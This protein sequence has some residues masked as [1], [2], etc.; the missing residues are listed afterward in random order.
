MTLTTVRC[1]AVS[2]ARFDRVGQRTVRALGEVHRTENPAELH[3]RIGV[4]VWR[5]PRHHQCRAPCLVNEPLG[6]RS[7]QQP[8]EAR[9]P[10]TPDDQ[11]I[12]PN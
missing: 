12:G 9:S 4:L 8:L 10:V 6:D 5:T 7:Q 11:Q 1:A 2:S 3:R